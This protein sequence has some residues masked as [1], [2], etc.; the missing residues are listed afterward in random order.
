MEME[1]FCYGVI[2]LIVSRKNSKNGN[3]Y[4]LTS[5][6]TGI[7][8]SFVLVVPEVLANTGRYDR[9]G[10]ARTRTINPTS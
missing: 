4:M 2:I 6:K 3:N 1:A 9:Q 7:W 10:T 5:N 8:N